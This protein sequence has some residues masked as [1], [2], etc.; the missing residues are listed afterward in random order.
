MKIIRSSEFSFPQGLYL[1]YTTLTDKP[2]QAEQLF[3]GL[4]DEAGLN[5][6]ILKILRHKSGKPYG[7]I[8]DRR[9]AL[10]LT[11]TEHVICCGLYSQGEIG[12]DMESKTRKP[13]NGLRERIIHNNE[14]ELVEGIETIRLWTI[15]E[16]VL[17]LTGTGLR[18]PMKKVEIHEI[19]NNYFKASAENLDLTVISFSLEQYWLSTAYSS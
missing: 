5:G 11:H 7:W 6:S 8:D 3:K 10:S 16:A 4:A 19:K 14:A 9:V 2:G 12:L 17:K 18:S 15:K 1:G 13:G